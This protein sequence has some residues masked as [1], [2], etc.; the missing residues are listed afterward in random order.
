MV[1]ISREIIGGFGNISEVFQTVL[2][3]LRRVLVAFR[4]ISSCFSGFESGFWRIQEVSMVSGHLKALSR[5]F[6]RGFKAI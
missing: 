1:F 4:G 2:G 3:D 5:E 6:Q